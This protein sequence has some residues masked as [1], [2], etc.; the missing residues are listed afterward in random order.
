[1]ESRY[2]SLAFVLALKGPTRATTLVPIGVAL[3][4]PVI[5]GLLIMVR[6]ASARLVVMPRSVTQTTV[7][8]EGVTPSPA[9]VNATLLIRRSSR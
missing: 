7:T 2:R 4:M 1:M 3:L 5:V 6:T 9:M 8:A